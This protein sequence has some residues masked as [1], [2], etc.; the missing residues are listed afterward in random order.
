MSKKTQN[1]PIESIVADLNVAMKQKTT[2]IIAIGELLNE[3]SLQVKHGEW[4]TWLQNNFA[5]S[6]QTADNYRK[7][8][9]LSIKMPTIGD[10]RLRP[11]ALYDLCTFEDDPEVIAAVLE[12]AK[13]RW[14]D[15][16][17][18]GE[19]YD[20][21]LEKREA[22][23]REKMPPV[24]QPPEEQP[25]P[26]GQPDS[27]KPEDE[28]DPDDRPPPTAEPVKAGSHFAMDTLT[29]HVQG[30]KRIY[31]KPIASF[32]GVAVPTEDLRAVAAFLMAVADAV[33]KTRTQAPV[34]PVLGETEKA[35]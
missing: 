6:R 5:L 11:G 33:D 1:R 18:V 28:L 10:L 13:D 32:A 9:K 30:L 4:A 29:T 24:G 3:V 2:N 16:T 31:T 20:A 8:H 15:S 22:A 23:E 27:G 7:V 25:E 12:E 21:I 34:S 19:I 14:V 26:E 17:R 35:A